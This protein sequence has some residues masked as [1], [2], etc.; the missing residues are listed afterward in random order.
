M[1]KYILLILACLSCF[2]SA[3]AAFQ[4][5][6]LDGSLSTNLSITTYTSEPCGIAGEQGSFGELFGNIVRQHVTDVP[7]RLRLDSSTS[8][9]VSTSMS[10]SSVSLQAYS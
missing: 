4:E 10:F 2:M 5:D 1:K 8:Y 6:S 3:Y 9:Q 7:S